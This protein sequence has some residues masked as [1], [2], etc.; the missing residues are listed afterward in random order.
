MQETGK[1]VHCYLTC[2]V[3]PYSVIICGSKTVNQKWLRRGSFS[4]S[5]NC[6]SPPG[7]C[8]KTRLSAQLWYENDFL[9]SCKQNLFSQQR[10]CTWPHFESKG[11]RNSEVAYCS[12]VVLVLKYGETRSARKRYLFQTWGKSKCRKFTSWS[13]KSKEIIKV[14]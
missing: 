13:I 3:T 2:V 5:I 10:L 8:I 6:S 9:F 7:L 1:T 12:V 11:F 4:F 14:I